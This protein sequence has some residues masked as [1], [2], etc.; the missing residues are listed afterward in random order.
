M[1]VITRRS[2]RYPILLYLTIISFRTDFFPFFVGEQ[3]NELLLLI[4][5]RLSTLVSA[6]IIIP[7]LLVSAFIPVVLRALLLVVLRL[8]SFV[9]PL[10]VIVSAVIVAGFLLL[11]CLVETAQISP[12]KQIDRRFLGLHLAILHQR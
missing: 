7:V 9:F 4:I 6:V 2:S 10:S 11:L 5:S 1:A 12:G 3:Q 8:S